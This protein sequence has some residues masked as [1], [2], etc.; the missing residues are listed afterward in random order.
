MSRRPPSSQVFA[1]SLRRALIPVALVAAVALLAPGA[2]AS[3]PPPPKP[4]K[5]LPKPQPA[6]ALGPALD[7]ANRLFSIPWARYA[8]QI[9]S[10]AESG[11]ASLDGKSLLTARGSV[12]GTSWRFGL[13]L[14]H[15]TGAID[16]VQ[17]PGFRSATLGGFELDAPLVGSWSAGFAG[18]ITASAKIKA[19]GNCVFCWSGSV[20][21]GLSIKDIRLVANATLDASDPAKPTLVRASVTPQATLVGN[22]IVPSAPIGL[23][24]SVSHGKVILSGRITNVGF[25]FDK[26]GASLTANLALTMLPQG[27]TAELAAGPVDLSSAYMLAT[28]TLSGKVGFTLPNGVGSQSAPFSLET[29]PFP[30]PSSRELNQ[31]LAALQPGF[32]RSF[33]APAPAPTVNPPV[34]YAAAAD[35][36]ETLI[37]GSGLHPSHL[38][39]GAVLTVD[40]RTTRAVKPVT[41]YGREADS[42]IWTGHYLAAEA[43]RYAATGAP[44]ALARVKTVLGGVQGL[45]DVARDAARARTGALVAVTQSGL[46]SR[47]AVPAGTALAD[48]SLDKRKICIYEHPAGGWR[49]ASRTYKTFA[50]AAKATAVAAARA[51]PAPVGTLMEGFGC[52]DDAGAEKAISRDQYD[53]VMMGLA[54]T[55]A[56]VPDAGVRAQAKALIERVLDFLL[57][58]GWNVPLP[59]SGRIG[60]TYLGDFDAQLEYLRI[61]A[62]VDPAKYGALY[63]QFAPAA[64]L[65]WLPTWFS[66][67]DP[68]P[69][70]Y[71]FNLAH[72]VFGPLLFLEHDPGLRAEYLTA[73]RMLRRATATHENAYFDLVDV[74]DGASTGGDP[75]AAMPGSTLAQ[76][77]TT[78]LGEWIVRWQASKDS[79]G[80]PT[81]A[82]VDAKDVAALWPGGVTTYTTLFGGTPIVAKS[83]LPVQE[84]VGNGID[85][86]WERDPF[87]TGVSAATGKCGASAQVAPDP[88]LLTAC[89]GEPS[90]EGPGVDYLLAY[91]LARYTGVL[92]VP[93]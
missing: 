87:S 56:L 25:G 86:A 28:L 35:Q 21:F 37:V 44:D 26:I 12:G 14:A 6:P 69:Q 13:N 8:G 22:G 80:L 47:V 72:A 71:K 36:L 76:E 65:A 43:F 84:R 53:G 78:V 4:P 11:F 29:A 34:T 73:Y 18:R 5:A 75:S 27:G 57:A 39:W 83:A 66:I 62:T 55:Y 68:L 9:T 90:R 52:G 49:V 48:G 74:L 67:L 64:A 17:P 30:F 50:L 70:Y 33:G 41:T 81:D 93:S 59:P 82:E 10:D 63:A 88:T 31:Y 91:W 79:A 89:A 40:Q 45:F 77:I 1:R 16:I 42:A 46:L 85:F 19:G 3:S 92:S 61:G 58:N 32:P 20:P 24:A 15:P 7:A 54:Y 23:T 60:T 51:A 2:P 38:P